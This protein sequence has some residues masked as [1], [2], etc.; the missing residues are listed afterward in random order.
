MQKTISATEARVHFGQ[1]LRRVVEHDEAVIVERG[2]KPEAVLL[3]IDS[4][5][6]LSAAGDAHADGEILTRAAGLRARIRTRR[7]SIPLPAPEDIIAETREE[8]DRG[9]APLR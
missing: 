5:N 8:R 6:R 2:G 4:Y 9:Y 7:G 1:W 3:S